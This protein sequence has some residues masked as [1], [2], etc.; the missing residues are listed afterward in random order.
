LPLLPDVMGAAVLEALSDGI[1]VLDPQW[2]CV[3][4]N[5][6]FLGWLHLPREKVVGRHLSDILAPDS[7]S[8]YE[9]HL[10]EPL[11]LGRRAQ[12]RG[13]ADWGLGGH[14]FMKQAL[15]PIRSAAGQVDHVVGVWTDLAQADASEPTLPGTVDELRRVEALKSAAYDNAIS[16]FISSDDHGRIVAFNAAAEAMFGC[17]RAEVLGRSVAEVVIPLRFRAKHEAGMARV[18]EGGP[19]G[20]LGQRIRSMAQRR[21]GS[22]FPIEIALWRTELRGVSYFTASVV[23]LTQDAENELNVEIRRE[24]LRQGE[25]LIAM[26]GLL[27]GVAHELNNPLAIAMGRASLLEEKCQDEALKADARRIREAT[28]RCGRIV[29][30]FLDMARSRPVQRCPASVN[31]VVHAAMD[32]LQYTCRTRNIDVV[33]DLAPSLPPVMANTDQLGQ[34]VLSLLTN[35]QQELE[36]APLPRRI[37]VSTGAD[38]AARGDD[39]QVWVRVADSGHGVPQSLHDRLFEPFVTGKPEGRSVGLGLAVSRSLARAHG[40]D[41]VLETKAPLQG[42]CFLF[43]LPASSAALPTP[44]AKDEAAVVTTGRVL[45]VDDEPEVAAFMRDALESSGF[46]VASAESAAVA[47]ELL[48]SVAFD[49]VVSDM[50]MPDMDGTA[51]WRAVCERHPRLGRRM[52][53]VTGDTLSPHVAAF[54]EACG[55]ASLDKPFRKDE[56]VLKVSRLL[57]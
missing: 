2:R 28:D 1:A 55:C 8:F 25:K 16:A 43:T 27:A 45:V 22:E 48:E 26:G 36:R 29:R 12:L 21:D 14:R 9:K 24:A 38:D 7:W 46:E 31:D 37:W 35:A 33:L 23:D 6:T 5:D 11:M 18:R 34:V 3:L 20:L 50:R 44:G 51:L 4:A 39:R 19:P 15:L 56:F 13:W 32:L 54:L 30:T 40:G 47:L 57:A 42:A 41:L 49:A 53:F 52:L 17:S 10:I